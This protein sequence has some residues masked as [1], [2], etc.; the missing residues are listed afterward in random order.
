MLE[1]AFLFDTEVVVAVCARYPSV[2]LF[3]RLAGTGTD[4]TFSLD[5]IRP[6]RSTIDDYCWKRFVSWGEFY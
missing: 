1:D 4:P 3:R 5:A 2:R 6:R